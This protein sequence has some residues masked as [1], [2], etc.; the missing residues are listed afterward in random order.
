MSVQLVHQVWL[1]CHIKAQTPRCIAE[2]TRAS[3]TG[4]RSV[5]R[6]RWH[7]SQLLSNHAA[8]VEMKNVTLLKK[9]ANALKATRPSASSPSRR[10]RGRSGNL[11]RVMRWRAGLAELPH[12]HGHPCPHPA[13]SN[14]F[15][16][17]LFYLFSLF[18]RRLVL[19]FFFCRFPGSGSSGG[20]EGGGARTADGEN[21]GEIALAFFAPLSPFF[22]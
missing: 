6:S 1:N 21:L 10:M 12:Q 4:S 16:K 3:R 14:S 13:S 17:L 18:S 15:S 20:E 19:C 11:R 2:K 7:P 9:M 5:V 22:A 8:V